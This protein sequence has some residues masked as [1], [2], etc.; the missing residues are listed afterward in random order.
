MAFFG[1]VINMFI[2]ALKILKY[3]L[4]KHFVSCLHTLNLYC[5]G[6]RCSNRGI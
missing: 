4:P 3:W 5:T 2:A 1:S 6:S